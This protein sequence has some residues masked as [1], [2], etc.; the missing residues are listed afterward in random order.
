MLGGPRTN[1]ELTNMTVNRKTLRSSLRTEG[2]FQDTSGLPPDG[3]EAVSANTLGIMIKT[4]NQYLPHH[5]KM[6][7]IN[8]S[9]ANPAVLRF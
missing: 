9:T 4:A 3:G 1:T 8:L 6:N 7:G 5:T 2:V